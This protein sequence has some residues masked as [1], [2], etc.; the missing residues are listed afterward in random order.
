MS[1]FVDIPQIIDNV[2]NDDADMERFSEVSLE[3]FDIDSSVVEDFLSL[4]MEIVDEE[5]DDL[6]I[7]FNALPFHRKVYEFVVV[8]E[9]E[10]AIVACHFHSS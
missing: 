3:E 2:L 6:T 9:A 1:N 10:L 7:S 8:S 4:S 5:E